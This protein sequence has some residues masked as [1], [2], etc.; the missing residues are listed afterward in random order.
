MQIINVR[1]RPCNNHFKK[2]LALLRLIY[3]HCKLGFLQNNGIN[4]KKSNFGGCHGNMPTICLSSIQFFV[5]QP[6]FVN[7]YLKLQEY[8]GVTKS[9][10]GEGFH[11]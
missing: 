11:Y 5:Q 4:A 3:K 7:I 2:I 1:C 9:R 8:T 6:G 10:Q